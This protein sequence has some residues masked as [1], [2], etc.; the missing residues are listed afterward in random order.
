MKIWLADRL[1]FSSGQKINFYTKTTA[2]RPIF[3]GYI[4][5]CNSANNNVKAF[6]TEIDCQKLSTPKFPLIMSMIV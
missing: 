1:N 4:V 3:L 5:Y 6:K 2:A